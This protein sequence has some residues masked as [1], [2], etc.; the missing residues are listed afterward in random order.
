MFIDSKG[1]PRFR[2]SGK[3][4]HRAVAVNKLGGKIYSGYEVHHIDGNKLNFR[5]SNLKV[6]SKSQHARLHW[7]NKSK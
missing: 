7:F 5:P 3:L 4:V 6:M 1:Y 2:D